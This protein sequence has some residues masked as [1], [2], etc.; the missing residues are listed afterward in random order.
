[1]TMDSARSLCGDPFYD[2]GPYLFPV[3]LHVSSAASLMRHRGY[4]SP[5]DGAA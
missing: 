3:R 2:T 1:M 4:G 5:L